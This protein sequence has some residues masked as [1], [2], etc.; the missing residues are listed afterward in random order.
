MT[1]RRALAVAGAVAAMLCGCAKSVFPP[2][3]PLDATPPRIL[4]TSPADS[5]VRIARNAGVEFL[6]SEGMDHASVRDA[7]RIRPPMERA[8]F[9]WDGRRFRV[10]WRDPLQRNTTYHVVLRGSARDEHG[11]A[12]GATVSIHFSTGDSLTPGKISGMVRAVTL[13]RAGVPIL[14]FPSEFGARPDTAVTFE[15]LYESAT[16]TAGVYSVAGVALGPAYRVF[17]FYDR[18]N[19]DSFDEDL[20]VLAAYPEAIRLTP[21]HAV[22]DSI[23][24]VAVDPRAPAVLSGSILASDSTAHYRVEAR[25]VPDSTVTRRVDRFGPGPFTLRVP[26]GSWKLR[27]QRV[28]GVDGTPSALEIRREEVLDLVAEEERG[29]FNFDFRPFEGRTR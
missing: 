3:G 14:V 23:N 16:D 11:I 27:A 29:G 2:G 28:P 12:M 21:E 26:A 19:N 4:A 18:N 25:G 7:V 15:P 10:Y 13:R 8:Q 20:D 24:I 22:A 6:F 1:S 17:A 5:S 9:H